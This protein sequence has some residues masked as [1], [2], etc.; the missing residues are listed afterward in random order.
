LE[1]RPTPANRLPFQRCG[2][3]SQ[4]QRN[5]HEPYLRLR[6]RIGVAKEI[7]DVDQQVTE[8]RIRFLRLLTQPLD[9][10]L[11]ES[12]AVSVIPKLFEG[13]PRAC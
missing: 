5:I 6:E 10:S 9:I 2:A 1:S 13:R 3:S 7:C 8:Q 12:L 4:S 11:D